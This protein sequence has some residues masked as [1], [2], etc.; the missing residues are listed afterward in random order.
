MKAHRQPKSIMRNALDRR[1]ALCSI[2]PD[3]NH[4]LLKIGVSE[5][6]EPA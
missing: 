2:I 6:M 4:I 1:L 5:N 3:A